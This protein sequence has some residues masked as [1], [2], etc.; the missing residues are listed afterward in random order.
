MPKSLPLPFLNFKSL[1]DAELG[2]LEGGRAL[3]TVLTDVVVCAP[4]SLLCH[5]ERGVGDSYTL[6]WFQ[7]A[8]RAWKRDHGPDL[9]L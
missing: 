6:T 3:L 9:E 8:G 2:I 1:N 7:L 5:R 4:T